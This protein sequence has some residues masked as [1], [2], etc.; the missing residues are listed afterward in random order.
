MVG[1]ELSKDVDFE[2]NPWSYFAAIHVFLLMHEGSG[3]CLMEGSDRW[4]WLTEV[5]MY[6]SSRWG[7][8][9]RHLSPKGASSRW[10]AFWEE[11]KSLEIIFSV[12]L[13]YSIAFYSRILWH[14]SEI[15]Y[16]KGL[17]TFWR[18]DSM[19]FRLT[20]IHKLAVAF[21]DS[22]CL[23]WSHHVACRI[24]VPWPGMELR[25]IAMKV[26]S[27]NHWTAEELPLFL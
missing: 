16:M 27:P 5:S 14:L 13:F 9:V 2:I 1:A 23:F 20:H 8:W 21:V 24:L 10:Y 3:F 26:Q 15:I 18:K 17:Q 12:L 11:Y 22:S 25:A 19:E 4:V 6:L 7:R